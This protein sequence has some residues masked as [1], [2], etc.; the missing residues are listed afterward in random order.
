MNIRTKLIGVVIAVNIIIIAIYVFYA[1]SIKK[2]AVYQKID[3]TLVS[4][5]YSLSPYLKEY[6]ERIAKKQ[7]TEEEYKQLIFILG[8]PANEMGVKYLYSVI[9]KDG[10]F[11]FTSDSG[12]PEEYAQGDYSRYMSGYEDPS[13]MI[14]EAVR[15]GKIQFDEYT[16]EW[17][18]FRSAF[19]PLGNIG[20]HAT[21]ICVDY[22]LEDLKTEVNSAIIGALWRGAIL[23]VFSTCVFILLLNPII[24]NA[25][26]IIDRLEKMSSGGLDLRSKVDIASSDEFGRIANHFNL[27]IDTTRAALSDIMSQVDVITRSGEKMKMSVQD[28]SGGISSQGNEVEQLMEL[29]NELNMSIGQ[30]AESAVETSH[31]S[32]D[33]LNITNESKKSVDITVEQI[34]E[35]AE[36]VEQNKKFIENLRT[37][38]EA[39]GSISGV[40]NDIADQTNLLALNAAIEA[41]RAGEHGRGFAVVA[42]EVRKLAEKTQTSTKEIDGMI[43]SLRGEMQGIVENFPKQLKNQKKEKRSLLS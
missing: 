34:E 10:R 3:A 5:A 39:I 8:K 16:D 29:L 28:I 21:V 19:L 20:G 15:T 23:F 9:E 40:I 13:P 24:K 18:T 26:A 14:S 4:A 32:A 25:Q 30:I 43:A 36:S 6:H 11:F 22:S 2:D 41:A 31:K 38:A 1:A 12:T 17:G 42:D 27:F 33:T 7:P 35:I 37:S